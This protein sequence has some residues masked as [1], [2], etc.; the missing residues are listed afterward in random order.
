MWCLTVKMFVRTVFAFAVVCTATTVRGLRLTGLTVP[1]SVQSGEPVRLH[2]E[3]DLENEVL[4]SVKWYKNNI[5]FFRYLPSELVP[6]QTFELPGMFVDPSRSDKNTVYLSMTDINTEG[7]YG[8]EVSTE[9]PSYQTVR[10]EKEMRVYVLP[11]EGPIIRGL[12]ES[13][14]VGDYVNATCYSRPSRPVA[15]LRWYV[16]HDEAEPRWVSHTGP[17]RHDNGLQSSS[18][19]LNMLIRQTHVAH[20]ELRFRCVAYV[21]QTQGRISQELIMGDKGPTLNKRSHT[22]FSDITRDFGHP[23]IENSQ[24]RY[25]VGDDLFVNCTSRADSQQIVQLQWFVNDREARQEML[26]RFPGG[27]P[28]GLK[29]RLQPAHF[30]NDELKMK[31]TATTL[32]EITRSSEAYAYAASQY[33]SGLHLASSATTHHGATL[34]VLHCTLAL[35]HLWTLLRYNL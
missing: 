1:G 26:K 31:C 14:H 6:A 22:V 20:G 19:I 12:S 18:A 7:V 4:Y 34:G 9:G 24:V 29:F 2:C 10:G 35:L 28:L 25:D 32:K 23:S 3:Y 30:P 33:V 11:V 16:N 27:S 15:K 8:C 17:V 13:Y 21:L 5:E